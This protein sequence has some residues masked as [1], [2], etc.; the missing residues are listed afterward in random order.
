MNQFKGRIENMKSYLLTSKVNVI[1]NL[2]ILQCL[3]WQLPLQHIHQ[4]QKSVPSS[5]SGRII[6]TD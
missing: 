1:L 3:L 4:L 6:I 5:T 2:K